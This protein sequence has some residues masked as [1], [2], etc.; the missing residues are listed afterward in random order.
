MKISAKQKE[1]NRRLII[2]TA[3]DLIMEKGFKATTMRAIARQAGVGDATIY[4]YFPT[5]ESILFGYY[6]DALENAVEGLKG[7]QDFNRFNLREQLQALF[8]ALLEIY[9]PDREFVA[10]SFGPVF[11]ALI[12][13][14]QSLLAIKKRFTHIV[15]DMF[16]AAVEVG[17]I[18]DQVFKELTYHVLWDFYVGTVLYWVRDD[19]PGFTNTTVFLDKSL[20]LGYSLLKAEAVNRLVDVGSFLFRTHILSRMD[21][22]RSQLDTLDRIKREFMS[23]EGK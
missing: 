5:K 6:E 18:S 8:E 16:Q 14:N 9:L 1:E 3:V 2:Q 15:D 22:I 21:L 23:H 7:I 20:A 11:M 19:S 10:E 12:P 13:G 17:E 4:N